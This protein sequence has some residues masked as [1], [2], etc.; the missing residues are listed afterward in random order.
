MLV[1]RA[2][3]FICIV[4]DTYPVGC[5]VRVGDGKAELESSGTVKVGCD[6]VTVIVCVLERVLV[7]VVEGVTEVLVAVVSEDELVDLL[8]A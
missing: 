3:L 5:A 7:D 8:S 4:E 1:R 2:S 6:A